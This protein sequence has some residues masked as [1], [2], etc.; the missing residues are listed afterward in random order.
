MVAC[1][2]F[3]HDCDD[4]FNHDDFNDYD[5]DVYDND[6]QD[7]QWQSCADGE[8]WQAK[9]RIREPGKGGEDVFLPKRD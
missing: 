4:D 1:H 3:D 9:R 2:H 8:V 6:D 7:R 5:G